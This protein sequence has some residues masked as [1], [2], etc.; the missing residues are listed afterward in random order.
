MYLSHC[1]G[2]GCICETDM[3]YMYATLVVPHGAAN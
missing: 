3:V 2:F 1:F